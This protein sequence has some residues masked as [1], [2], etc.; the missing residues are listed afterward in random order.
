M[1]KLFFLAILFFGFYFTVFAQ[2]VKIDSLSKVISQFQRTQKFE[3]DTSYI[4]ILNDLAFLY[5]KQNF[6][7]MLIYANK[8]ILLSEKIS[9]SKGIARGL[10]NYAFV[11][12]GKAKYDSAIYYH[13]KSLRLREINKDNRGVSGSLNNIGVIYYSQGQY[14]E[15]LQYYLQSL[16]IKEQLQDQ[17][18]IGLAQH[19]IAEVYHLQGNYD[20]ALSFF[21][22]SV[23]I[24]KKTQNIKVLA[25]S[26]LSRGNLYKDKNNYEQALIDYFEALKLRETLGMASDVASCLTSIGN[27]YLA[28]EEYDKALEY[29][30][31]ALNFV[32]TTQ[33]NEILTPI[34]YNIGL[35]YTKKSQD[36]LALI[37]FEEVYAIQK[38]YAYK[39]FMPRTLGSIA[40]VYSNK[41]DYEN[42]IY[43]YNQALKISEELK[44]KYNIAEN[45]QNMATCY[46]KQK[47]Q[48][49]AIEFA[50]KSLKI[51]QTNGMKQICNTNLLLLASIY[52]KEGN[53]AKAFACYKLSVLYK[54][55]IFNIDKEKDINKVV[56]QRKELENSRLEQEN[57]IKSISLEKEQLAKIAKD[58]ELAL[59]TQ[60]SKADKLFALARQE[61]DQRKADSLTFLAQK[62][63]LEA[64][65]LA[66]VEQK[67]VA[68][69]KNK[70]LAL[71]QANKEKDFQT[72]LT[73]VFFVA[74]LLIT[75]FMIIALR[76]RLKEKKANALLQQRNQEINQ[77]KEEIITQAEQLNEL[78]HWKDKLFAI[79]AHDLR[80][81]MIGFQ[82]ISKQLDFFI[83][84]QQID[85][86][87][88]IS[89]NIKNSTSQMYLLLDNLLNWAMLQQ[90][91]LSMTDETV[92]LSVFVAELMNIYEFV[93]KET[94]ISLQNKVPQ[95]FNIRIDKNILNIILRNL[96]ANAIKFTPENGFISVIA[97]QNAAQQ[98]I[99]EV[100]DTGIGM[101]AAQMQNLF[102]QH[103]KPTE[104]ALRGGKGTGLGLLLCKEFIEKCKGSITVKSEINQGTTFI[105]VFDLT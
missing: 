90:N 34:L 57:V 70:E 51:A 13:T 31:K 46:A 98:T 73:L 20:K 83:K 87:E 45:L 55:S 44:Q 15:A 40:G 25:A 96:L 63:Q 2:Q 1:T 80:S 86:I 49:K 79:I 35:I 78:N 71:T 50:E 72:K 89:K 28:K 27:I 77:Q 6:D 47:Q 103:T 58:K 88:E 76:S 33:D 82:T 53:A 21:A 81:P 22:K 3:K 18:S 8:A 17:K 48:E 32:K 14:Q 84:K 38:K 61:K 42:A 23:E 19:N 97:Y 30:F 75:G 101:T 52:E 39:R 100:Q 43:Y 60:Q 62:A 74:M 99:I 26:L 16:K 11:C 24:A 95:G 65:K 94:A 66:V 64:D 4:N 29:N 105:L 36:S 93:A 85:K 37:T 59:L 92:D 69:A 7:S 56:L 68:E 104:N 10:E 91:Q 9:Y 54:D 102:K 41:N 67:L 5:N 12:R